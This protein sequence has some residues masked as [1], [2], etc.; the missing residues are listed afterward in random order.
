[1]SLVVSDPSPLHY[2]VFCRVADVLA[3]LFDR[4][5][6]PPSVA[7][8]LQQTNSPPMVRHWMETPPPWFSVQ[9]PK[10]L[11]PALGLANGDIEAICLAR[12]TKATAILADDRAVRVVAARC[13][14]T[15]VGTLGILELAAFNGLIDLP[16]VIATL[17][18]THA[19]FDP[20]LITL[21]LERVASLGKNNP[22]V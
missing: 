16:K 13:G 4:V 21:A 6:I 18:Q 20:A 1:M 11:D 17:R 12:E 3:K 2:L 22:T 14:L 5:A 9:P 7:K 19:R 15:V 10:R 8:E